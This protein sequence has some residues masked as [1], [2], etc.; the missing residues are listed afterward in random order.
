MTAL[1]TLSMILK[2]EAANIA[3]TLATV[4]PF[5]DRWVI[6]DTGSSDGTPEAVRAA[7]EGK[8]GEVVHEPFVDFATTRNAALDRCG[9]ES[10]FILWLDADDALEGGAALRAFLEKHRR[11]RGPDHEAYYVRVESGIRFDSARVLRSRARWRFKGAV[12]EVLTRAGRQPPVHRI[13]GVL[14]RHSVDAVSGER[15]RRRWERDVGLLE[16][17]LANDPG[18]TRSAFYLALTLSWLGRNEE[19]AAALDRRIAMG[20]WAEEVYQARMQRAAV[21][22]ALGRPWA[23]VMDLYLAAHATLPHRAEPLHAIAFRYNERGEHALCLLFARRGLDLPLPR[24]DRLFVDEEVYTWK[25]ADL[26]GSS[27]YWL[28][29]LE[30]GESA[31]RRALRERPND[32]RLAKNLSFYLQKKGQKGR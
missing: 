24:H 5:V 17:A 28:G 25:L 19:A 6:A 20:G 32:A 26:V 4:K 30:L 8:P 22:E 1:L 13:D 18:D 23:E 3:R 12:H 11:E 14:V 7:M 2:D 15:S 9:D 27:A 21:A 29:E 16:S 31:A 10:E